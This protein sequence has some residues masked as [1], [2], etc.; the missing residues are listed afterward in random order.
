[1]LAKIRS[2]NLAKDSVIIVQL[3]TAST[4]ATAQAQRQGPEHS[5]SPATATAHSL[6]QHHTASDSP[7]KQAQTPATP[8]Q[9]TAPATHSSE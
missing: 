9:G 4:R 5:T 8:A 3:S 1:V 2:M 7:A 6:H